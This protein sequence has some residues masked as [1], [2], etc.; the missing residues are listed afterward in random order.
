M[1]TLADVKFIP[2]PP[3]LVVSKKTPNPLPP[4]SPEGFLS[5]LKR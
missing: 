2:R 1:T 3:A 5:S 4:P